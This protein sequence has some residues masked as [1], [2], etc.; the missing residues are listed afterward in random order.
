MSSLNVGIV[1]CGGAAPAHFS[2]WRRLKGVNIQ[3]VCDTDE[4]RVASAATHWKVPNYYTSL[5]DMLTRSSVS[6][7]SIVTPPGSHA[8][9]AIEAMESG[10]DVLLEK[11]FTTT[12][13]EADR[14]IDCY[15]RTQQ[16]LTVIHNWRF[17]PAMV[18]ACSLVQKHALGRIC[19]VTIFSLGTRFGRMTSDPHDWSHKLKGG[20]I[21]E[22]I[23]HPLYLLTSLLDELNICSVTAAKVGDYPWLP[24]DEATI[25]LRSANGAL[26]TIFITCDAAREEVIVEIFGDRMH[27]S[28]NLFRNLVIQTKQVNIDA[29]SRIGKLTAISTANLGEALQTITPTIK[30]AVSAVSSALHGPR[31]P[32]P[33]EIIIAG[34]KKSI[35][36]GYPPPVEPLDAREVVRLSEEICES[37]DQQ[38]RERLI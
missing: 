14:V 22:G 5:T 15:R 19:G 3:A 6:A 17:L 13:Q 27:L 37:L 34:F 1:G 21:A 24:I 7:V 30:R 11:P 16:K 9:L 18:K 36:E 26:G 2:A 31:V 32:T 35:L 38:I 12:L 28:V 4:R 33:Y 10:C 29:L 20:R 8:N 23:P 25:V